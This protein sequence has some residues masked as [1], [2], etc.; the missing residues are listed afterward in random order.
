MSEHGMVDVGSRFDLRIRRSPDAPETAAFE[1]RETTFGW[2][3]SYET[4]S[5]GGRPWRP[6]HGLHVRLSVALPLLP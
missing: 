2:I 1:G 5:D 6:D 3:H 4:G